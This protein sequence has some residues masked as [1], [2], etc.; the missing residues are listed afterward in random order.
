MPN[1][2]SNSITIEGNPTLVKQ[3]KEQVS[4]PYIMPV[5]S[6][7]DLAYTVKELSVDNVFSFWNIIAPTDFDEYVKQPWTKNGEDSI[8]NPDSWYNWN[9]RNWGVKWDTTNPELEDEV[10]NGENLV[11]VYSFE[12]PWGVPTPVLLELSRQFPSVLITNEFQEETGWG[13]S[14]EI[15]NGK[16]YSESDYGWKCW[17]CDHTEDE[18]PYCETCEYDMCPDCGHG[19]PDPELQQQCQT[20]RVELVSTEKAEV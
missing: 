10:E 13:G 11:L 2:V 20:H 15:A 7:G 8:A 5:E 6:N 17:E 19:E 18:T 4:K 1:W 16:I 3:I 14:M 12:T 9:I